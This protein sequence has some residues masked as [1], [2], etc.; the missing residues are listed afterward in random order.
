MSI[1]L[2]KGSLHR[3]ATPV[4]AVLAV[5]AM[6]AWTAWLGWD[7]H[8]DVH[9]DGST[10][11]PYEAWQVVG[12]GLSLLAMVGWAAYRRNHTAAVFGTSIGLAVAACYD[13][14]DDGSGLF[15]VGVFMM[16]IGSLAVTGLLSLL[17]G[18]FRRPAPASAPASAL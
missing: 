5:L 11:G 9:P 15:L 16:L 4:L 6:V 13:W 18:S 1:E 3:F 14:S 7:Q 10:T 8:R 17:I 2:P 12:L